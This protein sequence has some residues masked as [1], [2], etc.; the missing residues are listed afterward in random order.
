MV[1]GE[2]FE[3]KYLYLEWDDELLDKPVL[4]ADDAYDLKTKDLDVGYIEPNENRYYPFALKHS[5]GLYRFA[6]YDPNLIY[7]NEFR[8][9]HKVSYYNSKTTEYLGDVKSLET[10]DLPGVYFAMSDEPKQEYEPFKDCDDFLKYWCDEKLHVVYK[11]LV[12]PLIWVRHK[13]SM[14]EFLICGLSLNEVWIQCG[15]FDF[16]LLFKRFE[17]L[18][19]TP[20]GRLKK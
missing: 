18:D 10:F 17:F 15:T 16:Q 7:K 6:Y 13:D 8:M 2:L 3:K 14:Q 11:G 9:G 1:L 5:D 12:K 19:G 20:C 4:L